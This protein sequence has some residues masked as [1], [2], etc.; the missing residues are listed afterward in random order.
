MKCAAVLVLGSDTIRFESDILHN[1]SIAHGLVDARNGTHQFAQDAFANF[2]HVGFAFEV[3][4]RQFVQ[5]DIW[6]DFHGEEI[7][8]SIHLFDGMS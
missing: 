3:F 4:W 7:V 1:F 6:I 8:E 5:T 2:E